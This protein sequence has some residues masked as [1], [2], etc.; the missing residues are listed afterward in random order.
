[1]SRKPFALSL[2]GALTL[3]LTG[4]VS[5]QSPFRVSASQKG[6]LLIYS[7][8]EVKWDR[9]GRV[10]QDTFLDI[11]N[12]FP[13]DIRVQGYFINGDVE[14][15]RMES[16][17]PGFMIQYEEPGWNT[18][19]CQF[20]LTGEQPSFW[21]AAQ[22]F[23]ADRPGLLP[24]LGGGFLCSSFTLLDPDHPETAEYDPGRPDP[25]SGMDD[26]ILRGYLILWAEVFV[27]APVPGDGICSGTTCIGGPNDGF[28]CNPL[29]GHRDCQQWPDGVFFPAHYNHLKGDGLIVNYREGTAWDYNAWAFQ[30]RVLVGPP[31]GAPPPVGAPIGQ[32]GVLML[33]G[34]MYD[35]PFS[36][37]LLDFY[38][39]DSTALSGGNQLVTVNTDLTVHAV[40]A[41][42]GQDGCG[43][44]LT[45]VEASIWNEFETKFSGTRRCICCWD[46]TMLSDW[47]RSGAIPNHFK[48]SALRTDK[49]KARLDG[50]AS[51]ECN[52][53][54]LCG[55]QAT[56]KRIFNVCRRIG[57]DGV[58]GGPNFN[59]F[60]QSEDAAILGLAT[61]FLDF[62]PSQDQAAAGMNLV[63]MGEEAAYIFYD[64][65][66]GSPL[67]ESE[68]RNST[69]TIGDGKNTGTRDY[70]GYR[71]NS[72]R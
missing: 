6:S 48:R 55:E 67:R 56:L 58:A 16:G 37:L 33:N 23:M 9:D 40:S 3:A 32:P 65:A 34:N 14:L 30:S 7:K 45:K 27:P 38:G 22:G 57:G 41:D 2:V 10:I 20:T 25:E 72:G 39:T 69:R 61:K 54:E 5:A 53:I 18:G 15:E 1:M 42:L 19:D 51:T 8:I 44:V 71:G 13:S 60:A 47:V 26:R 24:Q 52:Y 12:D 17:E 50:L 49:G 29:N 36:Q 62:S 46:Q 4:A 35:W 43:P 66:E 28:P 11:A 70:D 21:S 31:P 68:E 59:P 63:G 64:P